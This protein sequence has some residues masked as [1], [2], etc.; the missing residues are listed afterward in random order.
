MYLAWIR[1]QIGINTKYKLVLILS[2]RDDCFV[3]LEAENV[4]SDDIF[5]IRRNLAMVDKLPYDSKIQW[6]R[7]NIP[8]Y[9]VAYKE[10][11]KDRAYIDSIYN[12]EPL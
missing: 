8:S 9:H 7:E 2:E 1:Y 12:I 3:C 4:A 5:K 11:H 10:L 6:F